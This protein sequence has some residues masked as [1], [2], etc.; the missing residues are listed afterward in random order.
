MSQNE[1]VLEAGESKRN[2]L[3]HPAFF[4]V[5]SFLLLGVLLVTAIANAGAKDDFTGIAT[6]EHVNGG[7]RCLLD[8]RTE[9]GVF[10]DNFRMSSAT[11][12]KVSEG[13]VIEVIKGKD[14]PEIAERSS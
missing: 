14:L 12:K 11:C 1:S 10:L 9:D 4:L 8:L 3:A 6:V 5:P 13:D 2:F 7:K